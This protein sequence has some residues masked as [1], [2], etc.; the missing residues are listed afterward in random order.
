ML[1]NFFKKVKDIFTISKKIGGKTLSEN[2]LDEYLKEL[3]SERG[4][5]SL[6]EEKIIRKSYLK[7]Y[8]DGLKYYRNIQ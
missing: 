1:S 7:G 2:L 6:E 8:S 5:I 3:I 4:F